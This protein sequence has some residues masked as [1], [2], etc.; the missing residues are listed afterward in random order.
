MEGIV[1]VGI[2]GG[3]L[4]RESISVCKIPKPSDDKS[5][6]SIPLGIPVSMPDEADLNDSTK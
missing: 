3:I 2:I 1:K 5:T 6:F 4:I